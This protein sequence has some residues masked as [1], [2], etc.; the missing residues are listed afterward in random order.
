L[1]FAA[2]RGGKTGVFAGQILYNT[3]L[4]G[5][6]AQ[7][8]HAAGCHPPRYLFPVP[9]GLK[10]RLYCFIWYGKEYGKCIKIH[11]IHTFL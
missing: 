6:I 1:N 5:V 7:S 3:Y 9:F 8:G 11:L 2:G 4:V 10:G